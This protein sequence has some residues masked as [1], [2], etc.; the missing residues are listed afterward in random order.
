MNALNPWARVAGTRARVVRRWAAPGILGLLGLALLWDG[1]V[2]GST[3]GTPNAPAQSPPRL[4]VLL[5]VDQLR[6]DLLDRYA[7]A[8]TGGFARILSEG[9]AFENA[10]MDHA[11][12]ETGPGHATLSTG[13]HP[14]H[15]GIVGNSWVE[16]DGDGGW[17]TVNSVD[18]PGAATLDFPNLPGKSPRN[19]L[20]DGLADWI[21]AADPDA[22]VASVSG[23]DRSAITLAGRAPGEVYWFEAGLGRFVTSDFYRTAVPDWVERFHEERLPS[24]LSPADSVWQ[25]VVPPEW[26]HLSRPDTFAFEGDGVNTYFPHRLHLEVANPTPRAINRWL[27]GTPLTDAATLALAREAVLELELG[28]RGSTDY[29][30]LGLSQADRIGHDYGPSSRE[31]LDNLLRLDRELAA[32]LGFLD[33]TVGEGRW[34]LALT[35]DHGSMDLPEAR[36][37]AG[38]HGYRVSPEERDTFFRTAEAAAQAAGE[39]ARAGARAAAQAILDL[40]WVADAFPWEDVIEGVPSDTFRAL[41]P[42]SYHPE[43]SVGE[44]GHLGVQYR[45][46]EGAHQSRF[47]LGTDHGSP[48]HFDRWIPLVLLGP[49]IPH[50]RSDR[51]AS[52]VDVAPTLASLAGIPAPPDL[53][54]IVLDFGP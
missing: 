8:F 17:R 37:A 26:A 44:L 15:H 30:G 36:A 10:T 40:A 25:S 12:T 27:D 18:D 3:P 39:D 50:G 6:P 45:L 31:Q 42:R 22:R 29:L 1:T 33:D 4:V 51:P 41:F 49:R 32:F 47:A 23:K 2:R 28:M 52:G 19:L 9:Y 7:P 13:R 54:G 14:A 34:L 35:A 24:V 21:L 11:M 53:D 20:H 46:V 43:R 38:L 48:Y 16:R 5:V